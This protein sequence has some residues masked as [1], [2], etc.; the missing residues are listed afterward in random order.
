MYNKGT[1]VGWRDR[2]TFKLD[3]THVERSIKY[4]QIFQLVVRTPISDIDLV[5]TVIMAS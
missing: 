2:K 3:A 1:L 5:E 4:R